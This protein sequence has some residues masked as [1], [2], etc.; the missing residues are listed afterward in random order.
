MFGHVVISVEPE[1]W[2]LSSHKWNVLS[3]L[4]GGVL[5]ELFPDGWLAESQKILIPSSNSSLYYLTPLREVFISASEESFS[6]RFLRPDVLGVVEVHLAS[7]SSSSKVSVH[8]SQPH[9][10]PWGSFCK[11]KSKVKT[12]SP[13]WAGICPGCSLG[14]LHTCVGEEPSILKWLPICLGHLSS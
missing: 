9:H 7:Q 3:L 14:V 8:S 1:W 2:T 4:W 6:G 10:V 11:T 12:R 5:Q 13:D